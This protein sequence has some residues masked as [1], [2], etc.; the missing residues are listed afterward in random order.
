MRTGFWIPPAIAFFVLCSAAAGE[1]DLGVL[2]RGRS[3]SGDMAS[4][5]R[6]AAPY[7]SDTR[8]DAPAAPRSDN[9]RRWLVQPVS[10]DANRQPLSELLSAFASSQGVAAVV[11]PRLTGMVTGRFAFNNPGAFLDILCR[12]QNMNWY[13]DG[14]TVHFF[15]NAELSSRVY[16]LMGRREDTLL[17]TLRELGLFDPRFG[18][19][20]G[21]ANRILMV[22]GPQVY[23]DLVKTILEYQ[24]VSALAEVREKKLG[25]FRLSHAW[26]SARSVKSGDATVSVPGVAD[27]LRDILAE[28]SIPMQQGT[29]EEPTPLGK[30]RMNKGT[31]VVA[32]EKAQAE[33]EPTATT[34]TN[35]PFIQADNRLNA[36]LIWDYEENLAS[37]KAI[38]EA[39]DQPLALVEIRAAIVDIETDRAKEL[40]ISWNYKHEGGDNWNNNVGSNVGD[41]M[42]DLTVTGSG[43]Q[44]ATIYTK[45]LDQLM[46]RVNALEKDGNAN[47]LSRPSVLTQDNTAATL[48][49]TETFYVKLEGDSEVDLA[50]VTAGLTLRVTPH[51]IR[52]GEGGIQLAVY[53]AD[54]SSND[55]DSADGLPRIR[56]STIS[57]QAVVHEGEALVI[58]GYYTEMRS[59]TESGIPVLKNIPGLGALFRTR[60]KT[61]MKSERLF[62]LSPRIVYPGASPIK[63]GS[64]AERS[65]G[66]SP[67]QDL[68]KEPAQND[69]VPKQQ[70]WWQNRRRRSK[71]SD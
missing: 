62:L 11:S 63:A 55:S 13:F 7:A 1:F 65:F 71:I 69:P 32:R 28:A 23:L 67:A 26:A 57:T 20:I 4:L 40:G 52:A 35:V 31:G 21:D 47:I 12:M 70:N 60:G 41:G 36:V 17:M 24:V 22:Q 68:L 39:L 3:A 64:E 14:G 9:P 2:A 46:A 59:V 10:F 37:H 45:G 8:A 49:H 53:I 27:L 54:G 19:R 15:D 43:L 33:N 18:W 5:N 58:G 29:Q 56:Q 66:H 25:V 42:G 48:E 34:A 38:I 44:Y 30:P 51:V 16:H 6:Q 50:D 61:N